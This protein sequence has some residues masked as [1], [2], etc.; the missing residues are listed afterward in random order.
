MSSACMFYAR[1]K[2][3]MWSKEKSVV[4]RAPRQVGVAERVWPGRERYSMD[5]C[6]H[7]HMH[8]CMCV[9]VYVWCVRLFACASGCWFLLF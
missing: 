2:G 1:L 6:V 5:W 9:C 8:A 3:A 4:E 7:V